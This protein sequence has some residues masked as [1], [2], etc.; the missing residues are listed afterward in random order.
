MLLLIGHDPIWEEEYVGCDWSME[1]M[2]TE[3]C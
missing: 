1:E 2:L 3:A